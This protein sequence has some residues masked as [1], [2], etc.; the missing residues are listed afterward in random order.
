MQPDQIRD[1]A[2]RDAAQAG[3]GVGEVA[4]DEEP[5]YVAGDRIAEQTSQGR[6]LDECSRPDDQGACG[7][8]KSLRY[9]ADVLRQMLAVGIGRYDTQQVGEIEI[10]V[11]ESGLQRPA[12]A[13]IHGM[14]QH[15]AVCHCIESV[16]YLLAA[17][18][19]AVVYDNDLPEG[20]FE[21]SLHNVNEEWLRIVGG[22]QDGNI[23]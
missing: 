3:L 21:Q 5:E 19:A 9:L 2:H 18:G 22:D 12:F 10:E 1:V 17:G 16:E 14:M 20:E 8:Q 4:A 15:P 23:H 13:E 7:L 11:I 6:S